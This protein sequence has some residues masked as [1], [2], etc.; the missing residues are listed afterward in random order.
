MNRTVHE[1]DAQRVRWLLYRTGQKM[2]TEAGDE[3]ARGGLA[4][5]VDAPDFRVMLLPADPQADP[6]LLDSDALDWL[7]EPRPTP[8]GA[9]TPRWGQRNR[10]TSRAL[11][12][13][14]QHSDDGGWEQYLAL[15]R[16]GGVEL[17]FG[18]IAYEVR[19]T[20]IFPL[21]HMVG[22]VWTAAGL[23][24][25]VAKRWDVHPPFEL[26]V[27]LRT[28][29][30]AALG[31]FAEG[32]TEPQQGLWGFTTCIE[33]HILLRWE[34]DDKIDGETLAMAAGDR[35]EQAFGSTHRRHLAHQGEYQ[36]RFDPRFGF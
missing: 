15:H 2:T 27:A 7:K 4:G 33:D 23:Q 11:V 10:A 8:Y 29:N 22:L 34:L 6:V 25:E 21:R 35:L 36:G 28:T 20:R 31:G 9:R 19:D 14:E 17:A 12:I 16:H 5:Y 13:Y 24:S 1:V 18:T 32:W 3:F 26:T 30:G